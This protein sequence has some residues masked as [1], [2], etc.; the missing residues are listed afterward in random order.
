MTERR[1]RQA[2]DRFHVASADGRR[3][4]IV[5]TTTFVTL[6]P[7]S[8][9]PSPPT[10]VGVEYNFGRHPVNVAEDGA[11]EVYTGGLTPVRCRRV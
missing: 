6:T 7:I 8:G 9:Q 11:F 1:W 4:E 10:P 2:T 5:E 3:F